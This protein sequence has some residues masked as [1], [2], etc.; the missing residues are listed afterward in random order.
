[1]REWESD[2]NSELTDLDALLSGLAGNG[3]YTEWEGKWYPL[4]LVN[5][6]Y[7]EEFA[8]QEAVDLGYANDSSSWPYNCIDWEKAAYLLRQDYTPVDFDG[9]TFWYR[10]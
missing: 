10:V 1:M 5:D 4:L 9:A 7:F 2:H 3:G 8:R 6:S